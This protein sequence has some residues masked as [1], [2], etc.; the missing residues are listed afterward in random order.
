MLTIKS[1]KTLSDEDLACHFSGAFGKDRMREAIAL[2]RR[3]ADI[4]D[5]ANAV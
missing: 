1:I 5:R 3:L 2:M 4:A